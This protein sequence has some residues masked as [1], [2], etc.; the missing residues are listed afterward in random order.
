MK[1]LN[2][3]ILFEC[4]YHRNGTIWR[5][6]SAN[7]ERRKIGGVYVGG[8][9]FEP[10]AADILNGMSK[11]HWK[12]INRANAVWWNASSVLDVLRLDLYSTGKT[13]LGS[14]IARAV[15]MSFDC[16]LLGFLGDKPARAI[17]NDNGTF[18][19]KA[20][21]ESISIAVNTVKAESRFWMHPAY[22]A[23]EF[24]YS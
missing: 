19:V 7:A 1:N 6:F 16:T 22:G 20:L 24:Y 8:M 9:C 17:R 4:E 14:I 5:K 2:G 18:H 12:A 10:S 15:P 21:D 13:P 3:K 11:R 23:P